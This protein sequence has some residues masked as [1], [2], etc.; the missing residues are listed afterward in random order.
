M[1]ETGTGVHIS[2]RIKISCRELVHVGRSENLICEKYC[3]IVSP[4]EIPQISMDVI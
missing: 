3:V 4:Q 2:G 1:N